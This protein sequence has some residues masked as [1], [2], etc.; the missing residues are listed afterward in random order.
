M[1]EAATQTAPDTDTMKAAVPNLTR[2]ESLV[3]KN[4]YI[5]AA[6]GLVPIPVFDLVALTGLQLNMLYRLSKIYDI[7]FKQEAARSVLA[8]LVGGGGSTALA[9]SVSASSVK[10]IP[11][12]GSIIGGVAMPVLAGATT[13]AVGKVFIQHFESGGTFLTFNPEKVKDYFAKMKEEGKS[14]AAEVLGTA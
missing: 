10:S 2:A 7:P 11:I 3:R 1:Q 4:V 12:L 5:C 6:V 13:Y 14:V 9:Q 8:A